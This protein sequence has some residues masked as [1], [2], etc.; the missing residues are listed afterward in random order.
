[1][2]SL[3]IDPN[4]VRT[5]E[6]GQ[7]LLALVK[8]GVLGGVKAAS[9]LADVV[10]ATSTPGCSHSRALASFWQRAPLVLEIRDLWPQVPMALRC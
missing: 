4:H 8:F 1:M 3:F 9:V 7:R 10:Y 5:H 6:F 2:G